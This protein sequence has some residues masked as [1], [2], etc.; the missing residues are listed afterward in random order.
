MKFINKFTLGI[1]TLLLTA[2]IILFTISID[3]KDVIVNG[4]IMEVVKS[5]ISILNYK[6]GNKS[7]KNIYEYTTDNEQVNEILKSKEVQD[8]VQKYVDLTIESMTNDE[9]IDEID[10]EQ[11]MINYIK[12]NKEVLEEKTGIEITDEMIEQTEEQIK[13]QDINHNI[14]EAIKE[15]RKNLT[16]TQRKTLKGYSFLIS[17]KLK[18]MLMILM[19]ID[20]C[21]IFFIERKNGKW[22]YVIGNSIFSAGLG[23]LIMTIIINIITSK[24]ASVPIFKLS[25]LYTHGTVELVIGIM[26]MILYKLVIKNIFTKK[27]DKDNEISKF[28]EFDEF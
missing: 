14:K 21:I 3:L 25:I 13:E 5:Q 4:V 6:E 15:T 16:E 9:S 11:D 18:I 23:I 1:L 26:I 12:E 8:L 7:E 2:F 27:G 17:T 20:V 28:T 24:M 19:I 22:I 10:L